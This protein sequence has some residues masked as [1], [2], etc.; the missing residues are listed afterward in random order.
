MLIPGLNNTAETWDQVIGHLPEEW[1]VNAVNLPPLSNID[2]IADHLLENIVEPIYICGFSFGGY[3]ALSM[4]ERAPELIKG[5]ILLA[6]MST[7]DSEKQIEARKKALSRVENGEYFMMMEDNAPITFHPDSLKD[8]KI[9]RLRSKIV[10]EYGPDLFAQHVK[11]TMIR[12]DRTMIFQQAPIPK[13]VIAGK[14]DRVV[15]SDQLQKLA[16]S[17]PNTT[18]HVIEQTGHMIPMEQPAAVAKV[19]QDWMAQH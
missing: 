7:A 15:Q 3:V 12:P 16:Q 17:T 10:Q 19:I 11:A 4:L 5:F 2:E 14:E 6:A 1:N 9:M 18:Y 13:L 8:E